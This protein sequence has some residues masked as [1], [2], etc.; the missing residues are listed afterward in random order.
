MPLPIVLSKGSLF[1]KILPHIGATI[2]SLEKGGSGNLF[3]SDSTLWDD[4]DIPALNAFSDFKAYN[5]HTVWVGPQ[6]DWWVKQNI[7]IAR[8]DT[9][10]PW[11]P[12][13]YM[14]YGEYTSLR[15][16]KNCISLESPESPIS[17]ITV[18]KD[19]AINDDESVYINTAFTN[20]LDK[21]ISWDIWNNTRIDGYSKVFVPVA[22]DKDVRVVPVLSA[23]S[24]EMPYEI[25]NGFFS[26]KATIPDAQFKERRS[27]S[28]I[29]PSRPWMAAFIGNSLLIIRFEHHDR[30]T[31]HPEQALVEIFN[32]TEHNADE[33][34]LELEYH[35]PYKTINPGGIMT[36]WEVWKV[37]E[38][39]ETKTDDAKIAFLNE[40][41][42]KGEL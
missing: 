20:I 16:D 9:A 14:V 36:A 40:L 15:N 41:I 21:P 13:P 34:L 11:P 18:T 25:K 28:Y 24:Q 37:Y 35:S 32:L 31:I 2:V 38:N 30:K 27:K 10:A 12:D 7:N 19:I 1:I 29:Y 5:G 22:S 26:Y 6:S 3:K 17:G 4:K 8:R 39:I 23:I 42:T 33:A